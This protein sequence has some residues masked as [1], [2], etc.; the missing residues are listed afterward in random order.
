MET[1]EMTDSF[2]L[3]AS[4]GFTVAQHRF[5]YVDP[6]ISDTSE[7]V[8]TELTHAVE[9]AANY[10][11]NSATIDR[12]RTSA[13]DLGNPGTRLLLEY[14]GFAEWLTSVPSAAAL[15]PLYDPSD[16]QLPTGHVLSDEALEWF[17][18]I[19]DAHGIRSRAEVMRH[20]LESSACEASEPQEWLSL[21]CGAAQPLFRTM[22]ALQ[23]Q[24]VAVPR[25][26]LADLDIGAL[27]LARR[28]ARDHRLERNIAIARINVL[29]RRGITP[30]GSRIGLRDWNE[31]FD[32]VDAVGLLE[33]LKP[34]DW[35]YTYRG[36]VT[37]KRRMAGAVTFLR[38]AFACVKPGGRL[39]VGT[40][41]DTHP[42]LEFTLNVVQWPHIQPRSVDTMLGIFAGAGL[43]GHLDIYTPSDGVYA[44]YVMGK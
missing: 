8:L 36:L 25:A 39:I 11:G 9:L 2:D 43:R 38:N 40:M 4:Y 29:N 19:A 41:L 27:R 14:D 35:L 7:D 24:G 1:A 10:L 28:Y 12:R 33:Y 6:W 16:P 3:P 23:S 42:Q 44:V 5:D 31:A 30:R 15:H 32:V 20:V 17:K 18:N 37:S 13:L 21:A 34:D 26:T 22:T